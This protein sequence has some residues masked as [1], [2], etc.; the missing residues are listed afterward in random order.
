M[1]SE[2]VAQ[3][4]AAGCVERLFS[5]FAAYPALVVFGAVLRRTFR[6]TLRRNLFIFVF[7]AHAALIKIN[8]FGSLGVTTLTH[9]LGHT[10][11]QQKKEAMGS[12]FLGC[13]AKGGT[14]RLLRPGPCTSGCRPR[15]R[16]SS[17][18]RDLA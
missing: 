9:S 10:E 11:K 1:R 6:R 17:T 4:A 12:P 3:L 15:L 18:A 16:R 5:L 2:S 8:A 13:Y 7:D 14:A